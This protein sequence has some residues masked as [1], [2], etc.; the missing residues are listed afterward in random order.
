MSRD[1]NRCQSQLE[2]SLEQA[3]IQT[4]PGQIKIRMTLSVTRGQYK[5]QLGSFVMLRGPGD[6]HTRKHL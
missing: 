6:L 1:L 4:S 2:S 3:D 5:F